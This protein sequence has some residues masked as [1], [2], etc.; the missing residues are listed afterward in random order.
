[1]SAQLRQGNSG[2]I[3]W[4]PHRIVLKVEDFL[5]SVIGLFKFS[6]RK[7]ILC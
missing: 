3:I 6:D 7:S 4:Y 5:L 2:T 1:M